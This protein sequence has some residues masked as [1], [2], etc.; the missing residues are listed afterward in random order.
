MQKWLNECGSNS[1]MG[2]GDGWENKAAKKRGK[3]E[4]LTPKL[5]LLLL[6]YWN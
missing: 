4:N 3:G 1:I 5:I 2:K 6:S